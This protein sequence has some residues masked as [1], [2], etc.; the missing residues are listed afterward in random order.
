VQGET[1]ESKIDQGPILHVDDDPDIRLLIAGC[2]REFGYVVV[3]AGTVAEA[4]QLAREVRFELCILDVR[5]PDGTGIELCQQLRRLQPNVRI[6][7]YSAYA[8][9]SEQ[10]EALSVCGDAYLKKPVSAAELEQ[11]IARLLNCEEQ[12]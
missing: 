2:L 6:L 9:D 12:D 5:L 3:T 7:Y 4:L 11:T 8:S 1:S 10:K